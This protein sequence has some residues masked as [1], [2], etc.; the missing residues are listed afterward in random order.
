M[1]ALIRQRARP[2]PHGCGRL[3]RGRGVVRCRACTQQLAGAIAAVG[4][5][6]PVLPKVLFLCDHDDF[7]AASTSTVRDG[8]YTYF[9]LYFVTG[10]T[11]NLPFFRQIRLRN[12]ITDTSC[13]SATPLPKI[14]QPLEYFSKYF[15]LPK[16]LKL[17]SADW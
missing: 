9:K 10:S 17:I 8:I 4:E 2:C 16:I 7:G 15:Q 13:W 12:K 1:H 14:F 6:C 11:I 3:V 5:R